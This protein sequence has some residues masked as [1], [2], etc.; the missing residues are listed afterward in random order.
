MS[1]AKQTAMMIRKTGITALLASA[2]LLV[3]ACG[4]TQEAK[5]GMNAEPSPAQA[6]PAADAIR[7]EVRIESDSGSAVNYAVDIDARKHPQSVYL[8]TIEVPYSEEFSVPMDTFIPL[9]ST[10]VQAE[11][12]EAASWISCTI[13]YDG[14]VV[15]THKSRGD[16]AK[17]V[18]DK[19]FQWGP[20]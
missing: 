18:C 7:V 5:D 2:L 6:E 9:N 16:K 1:K 19:T 11:K 3:S 10:K 14:E 17:A 13:L 4:I 12:D 8:D 15:A 20:G